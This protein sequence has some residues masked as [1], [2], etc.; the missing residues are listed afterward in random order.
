MQNEIDSQAVAA[1]ILAGFDNYRDRFRYITRG[2]QQRFA[3]AAWSETQL[4]AAERIEL[5]ERI[6]IETVAAV[7]ML[8]HPSSYPSLEWKRV[9]QLYGSMIR[10]RSDYELAETVF[11]T[12]YRKIFREFELSDETAFVRGHVQYRPE[13]AVQLSQNFGPSWELRDLLKTVLDGYPLGVPYQDQESDIEAMVGAMEGQIPLLRAQAVNS[14]DGVSFQ[15]LKSIFYRNK[16][17][18]IVGRMF[19]DTHVFPIAIPIM[20]KGGKLLVD[21]IIWNENDLSMIFSFTRSYFMVDI[22]YPNEMVMF[23]QELLPVKKRSELYA[24]IGFFKHG[25]T[26]FYRGFLNHL[27]HSDDQFV[28]AEGIKGMVMAV[29]TLPSY[30]TVF[31]II[32]DRFSPTKTVTRD[33]VKDA[34]QLVKTHDRVGRMA[35]TQ[36]FSSF[37]FPRD[38]FSDDLIEYL[39]SVAASSV[40]ILDDQ[41]IVKH[42]YTERQMTPLNIYIHNIS[43]YQL[44]Q[45]LDEYGNAIKELAAANIFPGDMLLKNFGVT[46][47]GRVVFYDYD[48]ICYLTEVNFR[49]I[50]EARYPEDQYAS[51]PWFEVGPQDVFP[52]EFGTFLFNS[53]ELKD[54]F[55]QMH[56]DLFEPAFWQ[57]VQENI[58]EDHLMDVYPYRQHKRFARGPDGS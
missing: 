51:E 24:S 23:L 40:E 19:I 34:Y 4:A 54:L 13:K 28:I 53:G 1:A 16:G 15:L 57:S 41:I 46:R 29:F 17:A 12:I 55:V 6:S 26:E 56:G 33:Q 39:L 10:E 58:S 11:N 37:V 50:P 42:L 45:V 48:E 8:I 27:D 25:K 9:K 7:K 44:L 36:E 49:H 21:T 52:E 35:D 31:K 5:Y 22:D 47:H 43:G 38:R 32:K 18:Y 14:T 20:N 3:N 2:A 30:Q